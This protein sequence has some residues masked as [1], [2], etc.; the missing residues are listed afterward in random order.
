MGKALS[1]LEL[2]G[3]QNTATGEQVA[4]RLHKAQMNVLRVLKKEERNPPE[5]HALNGY[6]RDNLVMKG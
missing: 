4:M 6:G 2:T 1:K 3:D 5:W